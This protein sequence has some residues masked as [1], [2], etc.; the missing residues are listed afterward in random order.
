[1]INSTMK[2]ALLTFF[3]TATICANGQTVSRPITSQ[4]LI[5]LNQASS[6]LSGFN[7]GISDRDLAS[8]G[9]LVGNVKVVALGEAT[10][11]THEFLLMKH[12]LL[13][14]LVKRKGFTI[15]AVEANMAEAELLNEYVLQGIG[16]PQELLKGLYFWT[17]NT[18]EFLDIIK[19]I[20]EYNKTAKNKVQFAGF[21]MQYTD[22]PI[23][24]IKSFLKNSD[25]VNELAEVDSVTKEIN[26]FESSKNNDYLK[27]AN[28]FQ[29]SPDDYFALLLRI[30]NIKRHISF[31]PKNINPEQFAWA[32]HNV[33]ILEQKTYS[34]IDTTERDRAMAENIVWISHANPNAKIVVW[35][36]NEHIKKYDQ[37]YLPMGKHLSNFFGSQYKAV[38]LTTLQGKYTAMIRSSFKPSSL[39]RDIAIPVSETETLESNLNKINK[40]LLLLNL[41]AVRHKLK[42]IFLNKPI[43][44]LDVGAIEIPKPY[45]LQNVNLG[46][47]GVIFI[48]STT[49]SIGYN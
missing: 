41:V 8:F 49:A 48:K 10:H 20:R 37:S 13:E 18:Q 22:G 11:G 12:R 16:D 35:A 40:P 24:N 21:D 42:P 6:S 7:P 5:G 3:L 2:T 44:C 34:L 47:D 15:F 14:Y 27:F 32:S 26:N 4:E 1:M 33:T 36:H 30:Q 23:K 45:V 31:N 46:Y 43:L 9:A 38:G 25:D 29:K 39:S 19:W 28:D 17:L